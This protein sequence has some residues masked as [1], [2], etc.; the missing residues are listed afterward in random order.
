MVFLWYMLV[1][2]QDKSLIVN[3]RNTNDTRMN[4][5]D[6]FNKG[7]FSTSSCCCCLFVDAD[8]SDP[9]LMT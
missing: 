1:N 6:L 9:G 5:Q 7:L 8:I 3:N 4:A 2:K